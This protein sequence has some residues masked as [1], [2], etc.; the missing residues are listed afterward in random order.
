MKSVNFEIHSIR[1]SGQHAIIFWIINNLGG[2]NQKLD[3]FIYWNDKTKV[4]YYNDCG[5]HK[6]PYVDS[7]NYLIRNYEDC[8]F[9]NQNKPIIIIR[10]FINLLA[11]RIKK[12]TFNNLDID[13]LITLWKCHAKMILKKKAIGIIYNRWL[14]DQKYRN[15]ISKKIGIPNFFDQIDYIPEVGQGSSFSSLEPE[16]DKLNY[17]KRYKMVEIPQEIIDKILE[18]HTLLKLN[19]ILFNMDLADELAQL[20]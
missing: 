12:N 14:I 2:F 16:T 18:D 9:Y 1:R 19:K 11:S 17:L 20:K 4:Y 5:D 6:Y 15:K 7:Y 13:S 3:T 10:D 8:W